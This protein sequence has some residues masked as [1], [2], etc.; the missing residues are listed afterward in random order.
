VKVHV[1][2]T[3]LFTFPDVSVVCGKVE[4]S[5][6]D[7]NAIANPALL[8]DVLSPSTAEYDRGEKLRHYQQLPS[9]QAVLLVAYDEKCVTAV[10]RTQDGW[11]TTLHRELVELVQPPARL[12]VRELY[13]ALVGM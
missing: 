7:R 3:G 5:P 4:R 12:S 13:E 9:L 8:V 10:C 1:A 6:D 11:V 2:A